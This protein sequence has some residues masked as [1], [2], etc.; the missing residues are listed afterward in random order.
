[1][2]KKD[3]IIPY[4]NGNLE[5]TVFLLNTIYNYQ[6]K[7]SEILDKENL[8]AAKMGAISNILLAIKEDIVEPDETSKFKPKILVSELENAVECIATRD[9]NG[10]KIDGFYFENAAYLVA[11]LRNKLAHGN[12][13]LDL[14]HSRVILRKD[15]QDIR[16]NIKKLQLFIIMAFKNYK[17][18]VSEDKF[19]RDIMTYEK[20]DTS[21]NKPVESFDELIKVI[22]DFNRI[23]FTLTAK[24]DSKVNSTLMRQMD[25]VIRKYKSTLDNQVLYDFQKAM[26]P[27]YSFN[28]EISKVKKYE[29]ICSIATD[30]SMSFPKNLDYFSQ[31]KMIGAH[32][33]RTMGVEYNRFGPVAGNL[34][35]LILLENMYEQGTVNKDI[36]LH[37]L[38]EEY[39]DFTID[40]DMYASS[41]MAVFNSL[42]SYAKDDIY[43]DEDFDYSKLGLSLLEVDKLVIDKNDLETV[44]AQIDAQ[45]RKLDEKNELIARSLENLNRVGSDKPQ[46]IANINNSLN[47]YRQE[48]M[49][50]ESKIEILE[51]ERDSLLE[52]YAT[53]AD[54]IRNSTLVERIRN[55]IAHGN[56]Q[57][58]INDFATE[59]FIEF[60]DIYEGKLKLSAS[61]DVLKLIELLHI[62]SE[63]V[64][65]FVGS[66][67]KVRVR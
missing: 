32:I 17:I 35:S 41:V 31:V 62:N 46:A 64:K 1:M 34:K 60:K 39:G 65:D 18:K 16:I 14:E 12:Y 36:L 13:T 20:L 52:Y 57:V 22:K 8:N 11:E 37:N 23:T 30:I 48:K 9:G 25:L 44:E 19:E 42:L 7:T 61:I 38:N 67:E 33:Q 55:S 6:F 3:C 40:Y 28:W 5:Y 51:A 53:N 58:R 45:N 49:L 66:D 54:K 2:N 50:V 10:Y 43:K 15:G 21:R 24:N 59:T 29:D 63:V 26:R 56:Y 4:Y 47:R 27:D